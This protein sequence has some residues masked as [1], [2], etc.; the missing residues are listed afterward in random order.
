MTRILSRREKFFI[1]TLVYATAKSCWIIIYSAYQLFKLII[2]GLY[3]LFRWVYCYFKYKDT[4]YTE[5]E[6]ENMI[7]AMSPREFEIFTGNLFKA[8]GYD[9]EVTQETADGGKDVIL[10]NRIY[11]EAKHFA[12]DNF[13]GRVILQK[14]EGAI[15]ADGME[16]GILVTTGR[17]N[18]NA[19]EYARKAG[20]IEL[21][22][23]PK[24]LDAIS[25]TEKRKV[26][27]MLH[28]LEA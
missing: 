5:E 16:S 21:W 4:G 28:R 14:L 9:V 15:F 6:I 10:N 24:I 17:F 2:D 27:Y 12:P 19:Y 1:K 18:E 25:K 13:C 22:D 7:R 8:L 26:G 3:G 11:V 23:M 20:N